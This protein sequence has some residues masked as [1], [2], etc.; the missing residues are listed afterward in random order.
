[1]RK[2]LIYIICSLIIIACLIV[3][4]VIKNN[5]KEE[6]VKNLEVK[7]QVVSQGFFKEISLGELLVKLDNKESFILLQSQTWC[8]HCVKTKPIYEEIVKEYNLEVFYIE[9]D[10]LTEQEK[11][12]LNA[13]INYK[14]TP[15]TVL[16]K[17]GVE[18]GRIRGFYN[19]E[20][21]IKELVKIGAIKE[22]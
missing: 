12:T 2:N 4:I 17:E 3:T 10:L 7:E 11:A 15:C 19:K 1:M 13:H 14:N 8:G 20:N 21:L 5:K 16:I 18:A 9:V 6:V 22:K